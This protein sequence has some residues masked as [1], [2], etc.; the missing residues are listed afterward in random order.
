MVNTR[1]RAKGSTNKTKKDKGSQVIEGQSEDDP[2]LTR[3]T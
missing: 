3:A 2:N 1:G